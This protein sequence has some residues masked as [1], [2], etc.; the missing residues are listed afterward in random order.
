MTLL[1]ARAL[2]SK[3]VL[4]VAAGDGALCA[5]LAAQ[6]CRVAANDL[7]Q[8]Q[9]RNAVRIFR[10]AEDIQ[11]LPGNLFDLDPAETGQF[12]L[13]VAC[14]IVEHVAHTV[15]FLAQLKKFVAP[16]GHILITTPNGSH[17]RN[18]LPTHSAIGDFSALESQ[19]LKPDADGHLFLITPDE[20]INLAHIAGLRVL[21]MALWGTPFLT[22]HVRLSSLAARPLCW[23]S[24]YLEYLFQ[25][26][27]LAIKQKACVSLSAVLTASLDATAGAPDVTPYRT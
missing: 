13:V 8:D 1:E 2:N 4:E 10:N 11:L 14:E 22:G 23:T 26:L 17:F 12:D 25:K 6:G 19:Q 7:R 24:Y 20:M 18:Q 16:G 21:R 27:P 9:L 15:E 5:S 3:S